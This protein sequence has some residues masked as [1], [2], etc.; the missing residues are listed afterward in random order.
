MSRPP[1][2]GS[3]RRGRPHPFRVRAA[4]PFRPRGAVR[5]AEARERAG[6]AQARK[7]EMK[8]K[9]DEWK[10]AHPEAA[11]DDDEEEEKDEV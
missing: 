7:A 8:R 3:Y 6:S 2:S 10:A 9:M 4:V 11:D 1:A 5:V